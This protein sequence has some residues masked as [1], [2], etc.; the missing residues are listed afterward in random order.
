[1]TFGMSSEPEIYKS[2]VRERLDK[3]LGA[4]RSNNE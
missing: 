1:V 3:L 2:R 4:S